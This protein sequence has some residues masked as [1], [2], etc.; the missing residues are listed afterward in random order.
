MEDV[1]LHATSW[2]LGS[3]ATVGTV[4]GDGL[5][6]INEGSKEISLVNMS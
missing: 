4:P 1:R 2:G 6:L 3:I 5:S